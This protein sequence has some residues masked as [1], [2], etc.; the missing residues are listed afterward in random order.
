MS[1]HASCRAHQARI[2]RPLLARCSQL[3]TVVPGTDYGLI[4]IQ[5]PIRA[6]AQTPSNT[7]FIK[8]L[9]GS[10]LFEAKQIMQHFGNDDDGNNAA[11]PKKSQNEAELVARTRIMINQCKHGPY[12][13]RNYLQEVKAGDA[14]LYSKLSGFRYDLCEWCFQ[15]VHDTGMDLDVAFVAMSFVDRFWSSNSVLL[16]DATNEQELVRHGELW[17]VLGASSLLLASD[18]WSERPSK[19]GRDRLLD[20]C[21]S[22][23]SKEQLNAMQIVLLRALRWHVH[24][25][26]VQAFIMEVL[27][28]M[29]LTTDITDASMAGILSMAS[30]FAQETVCSEE[31]TS[32]DASILAFASL[33]LAT[34]RHSIGLGCRTQSDAFVQKLLNE[35][36]QELNLA[37]LQVVESFLRDASITNFTANDGTPQQAQEQHGQP[38]DGNSVEQ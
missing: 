29:S 27:T 4:F 8:D 14:Y 2:L 28:L 9:D 1:K 34:E 22:A 15:C 11:A 36:R 32:Y 17:S 18:L 37:E 19:E 21:Y 20:T 24:P 25:P 3:Q 16:P 5:L 35:F 6:W 23:F 26:T 13:P 30:F 10:D 12:T 38:Q 33:S 7:V 31:L